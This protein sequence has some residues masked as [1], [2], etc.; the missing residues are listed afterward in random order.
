VCVLQGRGESPTSRGYVGASAGVGYG[1][2]LGG[3][4]GTIREH[5]ATDGDDVLEVLKTRA[6]V[7]NDIVLCDDARSAGCLWSCPECGLDTN[8]AWER[9][10]QCFA[11][12]PKDLVHTAKESA[13]R[14]L[15]TPSHLGIANKENPHRLGVLSGYGLGRYKAVKEQMD[16]HPA[17]FGAV[18]A[19]ALPP[20]PPTDECSLPDQRLLAITVSEGQAAWPDEADDE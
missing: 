12:Y 2:G 20:P 8:V 6:R 13:R 1:P 17:A 7:I 14:V 19:G 16:E 15:N 3:T 18:E 4:L 5:G 9:C 11:P 10:V